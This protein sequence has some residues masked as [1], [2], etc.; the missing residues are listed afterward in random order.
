MSLNGDYTLKRFVKRGNEGW[1]VPANPDFPE[2]R[3]TEDDDFFYLGHCHVCHSPTG[4]RLISSF[5]NG[6]MW[7]LIDCNSFFCSVEKVSI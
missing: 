4:E 3:V 1:L 2:I 7:A 5:F 6:N